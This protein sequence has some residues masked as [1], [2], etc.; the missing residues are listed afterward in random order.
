MSDVIDKGRKDKVKEKNQE[1]E[2]KERKDGG[3]KKRESEPC[4]FV[5][6]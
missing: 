1:R 4:N 5:M 3:K 2:G 6:V